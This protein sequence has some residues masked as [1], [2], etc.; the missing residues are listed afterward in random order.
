MRDVVHIEKDY[1]LSISHMAS[2][3]I[4]L[5]SF[6]VPILSTNVMAPE[7]GKHR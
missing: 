2:D 1:Y 6:Q 4:N 5:T 3:G 7:L